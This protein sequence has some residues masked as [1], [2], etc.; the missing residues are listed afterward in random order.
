L[1]RTIFIPS[2]F[3][4]GCNQL[5]KNTNWESKSVDHQQGMFAAFC[6]LTKGLM[7]MR[8]IQLAL[9]LCLLLV[10]LQAAWA[11]E[12][13][14]APFVYHESFESD[15]DMVRS[16]ATNGTYT[17][18][19]KGIVDEEAF[20]GK[21]AFKLDITLTSGSYAYF[22]VP[23]RIPASGELTFT[24]QMKLGPGNTASVGLGANYIFP[25]TRHSGC[26]P[27]DKN[28]TTNGTWKQFSA[29]LAE[30]AQQSAN[31]VMATWVDGA[32]KDD[33]GVYVDRWGIFITGKPGDRAVIYVDDIRIEGQA[34]NDSDYHE[35]YMARWRLFQ[36]NWR[37][38]LSSWEER[39]TTA[40]QDLRKVLP[41][42]ST[43]LRSKAEEIE[44]TVDA[45][46]TTLR[47]FAGVGYA[48]ADEIQQ[49]TDQLAT[50]EGAPMLFAHMAKALQEGRNMMVYEVPAIS[51]TRILPTKLSLVGALAEEIQVSGCRGEYETASVVIYP[52]EPV[53]NL[54]ITASD[55]HGPGGRIK[56]NDI[57]VK[58]VKVWYQAGRS[59]SD[60]HNKQLTP[61]LLL[62]DDALVQVDEQAEANYLRSTAEDGSE[63]Y[64]L[65]SGT[66]STELMKVRP[67]DAKTLQPISLPALRSQQYWIT[68]EIP[69]DLPAGTY[70]GE[71]TIT[72][73]GSEPMHL[74]LSVHIHPFDLAPSPLIYSLYYRGRLT[75]DDQ[76]TIT[77]EQRSQQQYLAEMRNLAEHGVLHPTIYQ[78]WD[79]TL[80]PRALTLRKQAGIS[81]DILFTL[82]LSTGSPSDKY[83]LAILSY[84]VKQWLTL[85]RQHGYE[86]LYVYGIDEAIGE[87]LNAQQ[88]AWKAVQDTGAGTFVAGYKG[89]FEAMGSLLNIAVLAGKP[90]PEEAKKFHS[91]GSR[92]LA[93]AF[94]QVGPEEPETYR[95]NY[96]LVLWQA[97]F[98]GA[99]NYAYQHGFGH[100]W[101]DFDSTSYRDHN[102]AYPTID[103]VVST[104]QFAG[105]RE[106]RD[107]VRY[108]AT[109]LEA[110]DMCTKPQVRADAQKFVDTL[111]P[112][113]DPYDIRHQ[114]VQHI[115]RCL[116][117]R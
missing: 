24:G 51:N 108:M 113:G 64:I 17:I 4:E 61:E 11:Q 114:M 69:D 80:L 55:L 93:Y 68:V 45:A 70:S 48:R 33:A 37:H 100:V 95:R 3:P 31:S 49:F 74:P 22:S 15:Q 40:E 41:T 82:G 67:I 111:D 2:Y 115:L 88:A 71:L 103:G 106:A 91:V 84:Q 25:P 6:Q 30:R 101:N 12:L 90:D 76:P 1:R 28:T 56:P 20:E 109:L 89:L 5:V 117:H 8:V 47:T 21:Q 87:R 73:E 44:A 27:F 86:E 29:A 63:R 99:M 43:A 116:G 14:L 94:P 54:L 79:E 75:W 38:R 16:W 35:E 9:T 7:T 72:A 60:L 39:L 58:L 62:N 110:I 96:G 104:V 105:Y 65:A 83:S 102:F 77:S 81:D 66:T 112:R 50:A 59:I 23:I 97:G 26:S 98:D 53:R 32:T 18:N 57:D 13:G 46:F 34:P 52:L 85:A 19:F 10:A 36:E 92:V 42:L 78:G 107:D